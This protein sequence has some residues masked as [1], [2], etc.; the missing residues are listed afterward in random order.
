MPLTDYAVTPLDVHWFIRVLRLWNRS[1]GLKTALSRA[2]RPGARVFDAGCGNGFIA[3]L[4]MNLG[5]GRVVGVDRADVTIARRIAEENGWAPSIDFIQG[6]LQ[7]F[8]TDEK[9]D[10]LAAMIYHNN[11]NLDLRQ[12]ALTYAL[13]ERLLAPGG[14]SIPDRVRYFAYACD[15]P[16]QDLGTQ[17][18][19]LE[20]TIR[21][22]EGAY[23]LKLQSLRDLAAETPDLH[24]I[25][26][27][28]PRGD[29][30]VLP[31]GRMHRPDARL[32]SPP[33]FFAELDYR[34]TF[35]GYPEL[36]SFA[37]VSPGTFTTVLW[38]QELLYE[39]VLLFSH[40]SLSW[41]EN[42]CAVKPG[43]R[44]QVQI[45]KEWLASNVLTIL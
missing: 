36:A 4:A 31:T 42:P 38:V 7:G 18:L 3:F 2:I 1:L 19:D 28:W 8:A 13:R 15:W 9:F 34:K 37:I 23:Q 11:P 43:D 10:V 32:L 5:A 22:L 6:E 35:A 44:C 40:E 21:E 27:F 33:A 16:S 45:T 14:V 30:S 41:I 39:D 17:R 26:P 12:S 20:R 24:A 25:P 29:V